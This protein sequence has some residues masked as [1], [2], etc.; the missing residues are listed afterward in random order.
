MDF[1]REERRTFC[2]LLGLLAGVLCG[3]GDILLGSFG[4]SGTAIF[5]GVVYT[6]ILYAP[7]WQFELS[8]ALGLAAAPLLWMGGSSM[9]LY[10][11][12]RAKGARPK[13]LRLFSLG[14]KIMILYVAAAHSVC[15]VAMMCI[16]AALAQGLSAA[17]IE[18][19]YQIPLLVPFIA[20]NIWVTLS[21]LLVSISYIALVRNG[22]LN[23]PKWCLVL[24]PI[25][26]YLLSRLV[27]ALALALT[28][29]PFWKQLFAGGASFGYGLMF[30]GCYV[31]AQ[32]DRRALPG[33][34]R[35]A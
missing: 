8:F 30:L 9:E 29:D 33:S 18:S 32:R 34:A 23:V 5:G 26:L 27:G 31:S 14:M 22:T 12:S 15:C 2:L 24:N 6:D 3:A 20:T 16:K 4:Q 19:A 1:V 35:S 7:F 10:L 11:K 13:M 25:C 17:W 21:E 28:A